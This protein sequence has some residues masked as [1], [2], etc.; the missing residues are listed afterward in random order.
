MNNKEVHAAPGAIRNLEARKEAARRAEHADEAR[1]LRRL[2]NRG[3]YN[4]RG[5]FLSAVFAV[6]SLLAALNPHSKIGT[7]LDHKMWGAVIVA[8]WAVG[9]PVFFWFDWVYFLKYEKPDS[10]ARKVAEHTHDLARNIWIGLLT[11]VTLAFFKIV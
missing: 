1:R 9:P 4:C 10:E 2:E 7:W 5:T 11:A 6:I 8:V 3:C